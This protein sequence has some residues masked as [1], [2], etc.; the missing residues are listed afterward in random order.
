VNTLSA[1][2]II[3]ATVWKNVPK[4]N[5]RITNYYYINFPILGMLI[6]SQIKYETQQTG[7]LFINL[8]KLPQLIIN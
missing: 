4:T 1:L 2:C 7:R 8:L 5:I 3:Y 6:K